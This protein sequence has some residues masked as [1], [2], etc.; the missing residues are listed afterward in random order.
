MPATLLKGASY[1]F[2]GLTHLADR[3]LRVFV[4][5][6]LLTNIV[7]F[8]LAIWWAAGTFD[9]WIDWLVQWLP[10]WLDWLQWLIWPIFVLALV[11]LVFYTFT[12]IANIVGAPF[13]GLLAEKVEQS[14]RPDMPRPAGRPL[15]QEVPYAVAHEFRK[16]AYILP[17]ALPLLL[18]FLIPG[19]NA[20]APLLWFGFGAWMLAMEYVDYPMGN[21]GLSFRRQR[22]LLGERR[23]LVLGFGAGVL[24]MTLVPLLNFLSMPSAV[25]GATL[26]WSEQ[27]DNQR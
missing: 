9:S 17:R 10:G 21:H 7:L 1:A 16:W 14:L 3:E 4:L 20:F 26:L 15:W 11:L 23:M 6:P 18:L 24:I 25:I 12:M 22:E 8:S 19:L 13:N 2:A 5:G 27:L